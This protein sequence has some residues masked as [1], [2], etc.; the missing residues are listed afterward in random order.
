MAFDWLVPSSRPKKGSSIESLCKS[1][2]YI[3]RNDYESLKDQLSKGEI[4]CDARIQIGGS[5][6]ALLMIAIQRNHD[7]CAEALC[8]AGCN[9]SPQIQDQQS[10]L[11]SAVLQR[12]LNMVKILLRHRA[13]VNETCINTRK[14]PLAYAVTDSTL[15][16]VKILLKF[17]AD[18]EKKDRLGSTPLL[19]ASTKEGNEAI[20]NCLIENGANVLTKN[21]A[22]SSIVQTLL[23]AN[24]DYEFIKGIIM[25]MNEISSQ[26]TQDLLNETGTRNLDSPL[27][28]LLSRWEETGQ[29][30]AMFEFL[31]QMG[32]DFSVRT[33][34][35]NKTP[36]DI[37]CLNN[38]VQ[39]SKFLLNRGI[40]TETQHV[41]SA[42]QKGCTQVFQLLLFSSQNVRGCVQNLENFPSEDMEK[43]AKNYKKTPLTLAQLCRISIVNKKDLDFLPKTLQ[44]FL[45]FE[46]L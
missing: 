11:I 12:N 27:G 5:S 22:K 37:A 44:D 36:F 30:L 33:P 29:D 21:C 17:G 45:V 14:T 46:E 4:D 18:V 6:W 38:F 41:F 19:T 16:I 3:G 23:H 25:K 28:I 40:Q 15:E 43:V 34:F 31:V 32:A 8:K 13:N 35:T 20:I 7:Q 26:E 2:N 42:Y 9:L 24:Y 39:L 10:P 1:L